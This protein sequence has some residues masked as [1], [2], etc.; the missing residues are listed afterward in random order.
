MWIWKEIETIVRWKMKRRKMKKR[1][2]EEEVEEDDEDEE[3]EKDEDDG[4]EP[5]TIGQREMVNTSADDADTMVNDEPT[6]LPAQGQEMRSIP[7]GHNLRPL[8][9]GH[10]PWSLSH[11]HEF[12]RLIPSVGWSFWGL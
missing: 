1:K 11:D 3:E 6:V 10:Q 5:R 9:H 12:W 8:T 2:D 4:K 7:H